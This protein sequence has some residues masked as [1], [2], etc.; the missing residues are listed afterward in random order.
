MT[1]L[2]SRLSIR[3]LL[4]SAILAPLVIM[5][6]LG[7]NLVWNSYLDFEGAKKVLAVQKV[8]NAGG[9]LMLSIPGE[10]LERVF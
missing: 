10:V 5:L 9:A 6:L 3:N 1:S 7:G 8:A 2:L 4:Y